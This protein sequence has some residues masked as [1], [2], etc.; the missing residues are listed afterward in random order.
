MIYREL[1]TS[2]YDLRFTGDKGLKESEL[3]KELGSLTRNRDKWEES[4]PYI[5]A[6]LSH[7]SV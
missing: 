3:Y 7:G 1:N 6:L 5:A 4:I 2:E